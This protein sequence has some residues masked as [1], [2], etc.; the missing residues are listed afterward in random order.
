[1][2]VVTG[3]ASG[4]GADFSRRWTELGGETAVLDARADAVVQVVRELG[5]AAS[6]YVVDVRDEG[7]VRE[8][9]TRIAAA[10][11]ERIDAVVNCAGIAR[12]APSAKV[13]EDDWITLLD[14]HLGGTMRLC[15]A[16]Y[17]YLRNSNR[18]AIVNIASVA[19]V[20]GM[21]GRAS[22]TTAKAGIG[23]LTRTLAVEWARD[24][25]RVN[26]VAPG[27]VES[28]MTD[29]LLAAG[30]LNLDPILDRT[31]MRRLAKP[32]EISSAIA[33]LS[34][35]EASY[36]TGQTLFVDGGMSV[37]GNWYGP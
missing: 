28:A 16:A 12:P 5:T 33:F 23:G 11:Q 13:A 15:R 19:A 22:Y 2:A 18:A 17:P 29:G 24:G 25:I 32:G 26:A 27:Y 14:V 21:P 7:G 4:I 36:I 31:P 3:G 10:H 8:T 20:F 34:S 35:P 30:Q 9:I 37:D 6:G 1:V